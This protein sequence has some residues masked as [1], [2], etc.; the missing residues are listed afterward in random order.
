MSN[1]LCD[2]LSEGKLDLYLG[3]SEKEEIIEISKKIKKEFL[4]KSD[5]HGLHHSEKVLLFAYLLGKHEGLDKECFEILIDAAI[6]HDVGRMDDTEEQ[7]H[8][9][10]STLKLEKIV[11]DKPIYKNPENMEI[12]KAICD[13]HSIP[14]FKMEK[15]LSNYEVSDKKEL[16]FKLASLLKDAD[17]LDRTRFKKTSVAALKTCF[18]RNDYARELVSLSYNVNDYYRTRI[19]ESHFEK[20]SR[21]NVG[22][23]MPCLHGIGFNFAVLDGILDD[24]ILSE[25]AKK[26]KKI[27][28][29]R[30][31][32]G[33]NG[34][35]WIS[36]CYGEGEAKKLFIDNGI[37]FDCL[38]PH[39]IKGEQ[40]K[41][42]ARTEGLPIDSGRYQDERFA[43]YEIPISNILSI[44][45]KP[46]LLNCDISLLNYLSGSTNYEALEGNISFYLNYLRI[47]LDYFPDISRIEELKSE[48]K[49]EVIKYESLDYELQKREQ[50]N[51]LD[52]TDDLKFK[53]NHEIAFMFKDAFMKKM[54]K[55]N[56]NVLDVITYIFNSKG[57]NYSY[58][59]GKFQLYSGEKKI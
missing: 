51:F 8:G 30:N 14:D 4:Y 49:N 46:E 45:L 55:E 39:L 58:N 57:I 42:V 6:Y 33:N 41:S 34:E 9:Y 3:E 16:L 15:V 21:E 2:L 44:N 36:V 43:F 40:K 37:Y 19:C 35:M 24:G 10:A 17:A 53:M 48:L 32:N 11:G 7:F 13:V 56:I 22:D 54:G 18:L 31:F 50:K 28:N 47:K 12:L 59:E 1:V 5:F 25:Y 38:A 29:C 26:K 52:K 20:Y 23:L 27:N